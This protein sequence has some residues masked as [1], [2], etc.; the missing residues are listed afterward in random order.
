MGRAEVSPLVAFPYRQS[1]SPHVA[2]LKQTSG[3]VSVVCG[4]FFRV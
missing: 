2:A 1:A 4:A 3:P